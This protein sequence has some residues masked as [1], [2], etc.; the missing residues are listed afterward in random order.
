MIS[1]AKSL[2]RK[3]AERLICI[4]VA[5]PHRRAVLFATLPLEEFT[6]TLAGII[7]A[8]SKKLKRGAVIRS[9]FSRLNGSHRSTVTRT[10]FADMMRAVKLPLDLRVQCPYESQQCTAQ[11]VEWAKEN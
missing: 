3:S 4:P 8:F 11:M 2:P 1:S 7:A 10:T 6:R 9:C 5:Y